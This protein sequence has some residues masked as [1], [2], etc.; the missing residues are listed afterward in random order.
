M[1]KE[2]REENWGGSVVTRAGQN[3]VTYLALYMQFAQYFTLITANDFWKNVLVQFSM[4]WHG[5]PA[6]IGRYWKRN[7]SHVLATNKIIKLQ[8]SGKL[9]FSMLVNHSIA[10][11][12]CTSTDQTSITSFS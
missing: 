2:E 11:L 3:W 8:S 12:H 10:T 4:K 6:D 5:L 7:L 9:F 1:N